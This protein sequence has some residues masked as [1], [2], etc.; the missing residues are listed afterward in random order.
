MIDEFRSHGN[1]FLK[2]LDLIFDHRDRF[3]GGKLTLAVKQMRKLADLLNAQLFDDFN[4]FHRGL[5]LTGVRQPPKFPS[6][7]LW[8]LFREM[9]LPSRYRQDRDLSYADYQNGVAALAGAFDSGKLVAAFQLARDHRLLQGLA[10]FNAASGQVARLKSEN[11]DWS[12]PRIRRE[13][14]A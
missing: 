4:M 10:T 9:V 5:I 1:Y 7:V 3:K 2:M 12:V 14:G 6:K 13:L 8:E 11:P